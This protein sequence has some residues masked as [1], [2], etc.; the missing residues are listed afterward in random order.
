[1]LVERDRD[2]GDF[3]TRRNANGS[4]QGRS[5]G[6]GRQVQAVAK[7]PAFTANLTLTTRSNKQSILILSDRRPPQGKHRA[8]SLLLVCQKGHSLLE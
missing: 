5:S 2:P 1:L 6:N 4:L 3:G 8:R 7:G